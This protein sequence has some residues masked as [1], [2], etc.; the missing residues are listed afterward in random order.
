MIHRLLILLLVVVLAVGVR[1]QTPAKT[2]DDTT[3]TIS[4]RVVNDS[5]QPLAGALLFARPMNS[6]ATPRSTTSDAD[7]NFRLIGLEPALYTINAT[8]PAYA[9]DNTVALTTY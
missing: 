4:G 6:L 1:A 7:G 8:A 9:T 5:G 3:G 2:T